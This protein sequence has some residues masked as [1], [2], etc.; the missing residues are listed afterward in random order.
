M[1]RNLK[2]IFIAL[3]LL[4]TISSKGA[5]NVPVVVTSKWLRENL[6]KQDLVI[7]QVSSILRDYENGH[8]PG[9]GFLWPGW[10]SVSTE[11][12]S[13]VPA[14]IK[15]V[16]KV[17][18]TLGVANESHIVLCGVYGN[19]MA[20]CRA[21]VMLE[22]FG[23]KGK[24]SILQGGYEDWINE[25]GEVSVLPSTLRKKKLLLSTQ[26]NLVDSELMKSITGKAGYQIVDARPKQYYEGSSG[27]SRKGHIPGAKN[28]SST[29]LYDGNSIHFHS[30]EKLK[31]IFSALEIPE[32][33]KTV[34][35]CNTGNLA[36]IDYVA[37]R[38][39]GLNPYLYDGSME[40]WG[41]RF[42]LPIEK[43]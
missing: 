16:R 14:D 12:E 17:L 15:Q 36:S 22:H 3:F 6:G 2:S 30:P 38:I 35:Y 18:E 5:E 26:D 7:L 33:A 9:A 25:G 28:L 21:F 39:V 23:L 11:T 4:L 42:E 19:L 10:L 41:S 34:F 24:V 40:D 32:G 37:A 13:T 43:Q 29:E 8:I 1:K 27:I 31:E 20:V